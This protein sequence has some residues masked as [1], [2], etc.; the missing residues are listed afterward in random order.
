MIRP[1][2]AALIALAAVSVPAAVAAQDATAV[3]DLFKPGAQIMGNDGKVLG[4]VKSIG[5]DSFVLTSPAGPVTVPRNW[6]EL[7]S[8]GLFID[9]ATPDIAKMAKVQAKQ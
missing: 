2:A 7:G 5:T 4:K 6:V 1:F 9:K 3:G 8:M